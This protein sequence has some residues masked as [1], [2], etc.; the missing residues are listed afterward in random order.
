MLPPDMGGPLAGTRAVEMA[1]FISGP[2]AGMLLADLGADVVK[3]E[4]PKTGDPF[5]PP[6]S[7]SP[8]RPVRTRATQ[9]TGRVTPDTPKRIAAG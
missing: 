1:S 9:N 8:H 2:C 4:L 6:A 7:V 5:S 3:V